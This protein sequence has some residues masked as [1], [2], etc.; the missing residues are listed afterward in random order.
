LVKS[1]VVN[2][3]A[4]PEPE[5]L[6]RRFPAGRDAVLAELLRLHYSSVWRMLRRVGVD[7]SRVEDA[8]QEV[9][10]IASRKLEHIKPGCERSYL[11]NSALRVAANF[12]RSSRTRREVFDDVLIDTASDPV[13]SA[14]SLLSQ[15]RLRT[16][17]DDILNAWPS[18]IRTAFVLFE[19]D[20]KSVPEIAELTE[21]AAGTVASR[22]RRGRELFLGAVK[23]L[24]A[25]GLLDGGSP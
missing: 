16:L 7:E 10:I 13:P 8:A 3:E 11:L 19:L 6:E 15:K 24:K 18:E 14:E 5:S 4:L 21:V 12:R 23:R 22:L 20:G 9:F 17:L 1:G 2:R 25:R